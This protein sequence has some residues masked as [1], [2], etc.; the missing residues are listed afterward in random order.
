MEVA[1]SGRSIMRKT[2]V[3]HT[4][5]T[6]IKIGG[7]IRRYRADTLAQTEMETGEGRRVRGNSSLEREREQQAEQSRRG[8]KGG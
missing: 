4:L 5:E 7:G 1:G 2:N 6:V 3:S 8:N